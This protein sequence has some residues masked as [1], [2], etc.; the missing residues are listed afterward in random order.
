MAAIAR[1]IY[2]EPGTLYARCGGVFGV[3]SFVDRCM[4]LW[5]ADPTLNDN[6][7]V[8]RWHTSAQRPGFKF[9]VVQIVCSLTGGPQEYTGRPMDEAH[10]HLNI[11]EGEWDRFM[12]IFNDVCGEFGLPSEDIDDLNALM[13]SMMDECV[14]YPGERPRRDPGPMRP[15]GNSLYA[16]CGGVYPIA[17]LCDRLVDALLADERVEI[18]TD[19]TKRNEAS[20]KYLTT[21]VV[22][23]LAGGPEVI[24]CA[25]SEETRL[26]VPK[27]SWPIFLLTANLAADHLP[28]R[29]R[30]AIATLL[31]NS[32]AHFVDP[33]S[34]EGRP[35]RGVAANR[36]AQVKSKESA[37]WDGG[38]KLLSKAVINARHSSAGASVAARKRVYGDPRTLYGKGGGVF[39]LA[40]LAHAL[41]EDWMA[42]PTLN[43]NAK[44]ARWHESQQKAGFKFL[45]T[46]IMGY[47]AGGPQRYTGRPLAEAHM[48]LAISANEWDVFMR[49]A[50]GTFEKVH[51]PIAAR[52]EL[53]EILDGFRSQ[54]VLPAGTT[55][56]P[57]PGAPRPHPS[58]VG[59]AFHRLGGVYPIAQ[60]A[61]R[62]VALLR[63]ESGQ[64]QV[65][66]HFEE[67]DAPDARRHAPGL[68][69]L[70]TEQ[71][72]AAAGGNGYVVTARG[73]DEA[74]LG[75]PADE[76]A[77]F[78]VLASEAAVGVF[79]T[80]HHRAMILDIL[81]ECRAELCHGDVGM[82]DANHN[83]ARQIEAAGFERF[84]AIAALDQSNGNAE[85]ALELL[86]TGW[87]PEP[88]AVPA[89]AAGGCPFGYGG[90]NGK[91]PAGA[92]APPRSAQQSSPGGMRGMVQ[93]AT[94]AFASLASSAFATASSNNNN[95]KRAKT[96]NGAA[97]CP[98]MAGG[99]SAASAAALPPGH[100]PVPGHMMPSA[101]AAAPA[102]AAEPASLPPNL[103]ETVRTM[104]QLGGQSAEQIAT[105][106]N[107]DLDAVRATLEPPRSSAAGGGVAPLPAALAEA[108][109]T[110]ADRGVGVP[111]IALLLKVDAARVQATID[112]ASSAEAMDTSAGG[113]A[114]GGGHTKLVGDPM[115]AR[116]DDLLEEEASLCCPVTLV[117]L[118]E[119]V[120][121]KDGHV[122]EKSAAEALVEN[123][124]FVSPMTREAL[125][126]E[127]PPNAALR[128]R[129]LTF[130]RERSGAMLTFAE[131][132]AGSHPELAMGVVDRLSEYLA[133]M[134]AEAVA[135][136]APQTGRAC[137]ALLRAART[138][139]Q[140]EGSWEARPQ[141]LRRLHALKAQ[142]RAGG[143]GA[144]LRQLTCLVC[145][146]EY[147]A[148]KG[149][150][151]GGE[152][153]AGEGGD[154]AGAEGAAGGG[155]GA[156]AER[157]FVCEECFAGHVGASVADDSIELFTQRGGVRCV[158]PECRAAPFADGALARC[159]PS[160]AFDR[161]SKAKERV[162]E[163][164]INA[165]LEAGFEERLRRERERAG[166]ANREAI[167]EHIVEKILTLRCPRCSQAFI[168]FSG[169]LA[170][171]CSRAGCGCGFC[172]LCQADCGNDAHK[173]VGDGCP[174]LEQ[175]GAAG[176]QYRNFHLTEDAFDEVQ[177]H[178]RTRALTAY[179]ATLTEAQKQ[180]ALADCARELADLG[181][182]PGDFGAADQEARRGFI[183][184]LP[185]PAANRP[186]R[187]RGRA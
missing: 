155:G 94:D 60:F 153:A 30:N 82:H 5:M 131:E 78:C 15:G 170:L 88:V 180:H 59:T 75:V 41:M 76:W 67:I 91:Q 123:G 50:N 115:Q 8:V 61:D 20:L 169:C 84:D 174:L 45:V 135:M 44:V 52:R 28:E 150:E 127:L 96:T 176:A 26:L 13:I 160:D 105:M 112:A 19:G 158:H 159:L 182:R 42:D 167:K 80:S 65:N 100:P 1:R 54:C 23:H 14:V 85:K 37:S 97:V 114:G 70:L 145:F 107:L 164:R 175:M 183:G 48:H 144:D 92:A 63:S 154:A 58:T 83:P 130:R 171:T 35:K 31:E 116:L 62:L 64:R 103:A 172:G 118:V 163:Q 87:R 104:A 55:A 147:P 86:V 29:Q 3:S 142:V 43:G 68:T 90:G 181:L 95:S 122:Y 98:F 71:L 6:K 7:M 126:A 101:A 111:Q 156:A 186:R 166:G 129:A 73:F 93:Q 18:P 179:L 177:K 21:E 178:R 165:E 39:G 140:P 151:C 102:P 66:V 141:Q 119:P 136:L 113:G 133:A 32:K 168:D 132:T 161:Y 11:S 72:C 47:M 99:A 34:A 125:P 109:L 27:S 74:R 40:K 110:M 185:A 16:R 120:T 117:L 33:S 53:V 38:G 36:A 149:I 69:Y 146:D 79:P 152:A 124:N 46:Q 17:L 22:C 77:A 138:P 24:T 162:A 89:A 25:Q 49:V 184:G 173:H 143:G 12:S 9:L 134:P 148:L 10:K 57:D 81:N 128:D 108:A 137:D 106:L 2:G 51:V 157:H 121:A 4:D 187:G 56:P 139:E